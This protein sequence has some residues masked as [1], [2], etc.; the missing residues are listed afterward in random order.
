M[1]LYLLRVFMELVSLRLRLSLMEQAKELLGVNLNDSVVADDMTILL[2]VIRELEKVGS[3]LAS[4]TLSNFTIKNFILSF[5][6]AIS[7]S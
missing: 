2:C 7:L 6:S 5:S 3:Y 1:F 4:W